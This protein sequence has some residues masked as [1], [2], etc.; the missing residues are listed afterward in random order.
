MS[1][2]STEKS[3]PTSFKNK[4]VLDVSFIS[5]WRKEGNILAKK[6]LSSAF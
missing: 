5:D 1:I 6:R 2:K 3:S 4:D